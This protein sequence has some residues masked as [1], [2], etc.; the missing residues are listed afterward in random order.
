MLLQRLRISEPTLEAAI[1]YNLV[2]L[3]LVDPEG[4]FID[5]AHALSLINCATNFMDDY[6]VQN[7]ILGQLQHD[8]NV[9]FELILS[10][11]PIGLQSMFQVRFVIFIYNFSLMFSLQKYLAATPTLIRADATELG[12]G[13]EDSLRRDY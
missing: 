12:G 1:V 5:V 7:D 13:A 6:K 9:W 2:D 3:A 10:Q 8:A 11:A 4:S